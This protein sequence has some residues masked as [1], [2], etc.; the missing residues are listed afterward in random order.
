MASAEFGCCCCLFAAAAAAEPK[1]T[2]A[3]EADTSSVSELSAPNRCE[4]SPVRWAAN[5][6]GLAERRCSAGIGADGWFAGRAA[7]AAAAAEWAC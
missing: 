3:V 6:L 7:V 4:P 1:L 5:E 2:E